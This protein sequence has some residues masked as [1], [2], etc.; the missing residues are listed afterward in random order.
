MILVQDKGDSSEFPYEYI[1]GTCW[2]D[3]D[4]FIEHEW[5]PGDY[6]VYI[7]FHWNDPEKYND[8]IFKTYSKVEPKI[9]EFK[10]ESNLEFLE[11]ALK[12]LARKQSK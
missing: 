5:T 11:N 9:E 7:E 2:K 10:Q 4:S 3:E 12:S 6:L 1:G 8:F